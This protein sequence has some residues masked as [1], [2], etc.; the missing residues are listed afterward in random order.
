M[1][2]T[3]E[4]TYVQFPLPLLAVGESFFDDTIRMIWGYGIY[5]AGRQAILD[6]TY[7]LSPSLE[8]CVAKGMEIVNTPDRFGEEILLLYCEEA[9]RLLSEQFPG[10][11]WAYVRLR[12]DIATDALF[13]RALNENDFRVLIAIYSSLGDSQF[14]LIRS[15]VITRRASGYMTEAEMNQHVQNQTDVRL[16]TLTPAQVKHS[17]AK[18]EDRGFFVKLTIGRRDSYFS[19]RLTLPVLSRRVVQARTARHQRAARRR[20]ISENATAII[21]QRRSGVA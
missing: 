8:Q 2:D 7:D 21:R 13:A 14:Q 4:D 6:S 3:R 12:A 1:P 11:R 5:Y 16:A 19:N 10:G 9:I 18:L 15:S 17:I 20:Q